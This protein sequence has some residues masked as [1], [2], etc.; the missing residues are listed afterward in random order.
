LT[1]SRDLSPAAVREQLSKLEA[2]SQFSG[3]GRLIELLRFIVEETLNDGGVALKEST[4]GNAVYGR[5]PPYDPRI[6]STV[7]VEARRLRD[8][9]RDYYAAE[10]KGDP[11]VISL[12]TG[13]Y[14]PTFSKA[15]PD[16]LDGNHSSS[17]EAEKDGL[18][19]AG[20]GAALAIMPFR[21]LSG[22]PQDDSFADGLTDELIF[23]LE[24]I[25][26]LWVASRSVV[27]QYKDRAY[28][29]PILAA[30][31]GVNA[32]L[33][34]TVRRE[35]DTIRATVELADPKGFV[36]WTDRFDVR[37][38][39]RLVL[40]E[41]IARTLFSRFRL[42]NSMMRGM[43]IS[44][45]PAALHALAKI[46]R[47]RQ[48]LDRQT[49]PDLQAALELFSDVAKEAPT[50]ARGYTGIADTYCDL[51]RLG[52]VDHSTASAS[53]NFAVGRALQLD[54]QSAEAHTASATI[55]AWLDRNP[56]AAIK[57]FEVALSLGEGAR[58]SRIYGVMLAFTG[59]HDEAA[60]LFRNARAMEPFS[61]Q[62]D[63][64]ETVCHYQAR[65]Y[66]DV[67]EVPH[68]ERSQSNSAELLV[69]KALASVFSGNTD[70][71]TAM[72]P[73]IDHIS[74]KYPDLVFSGAEIEAW[75]GL[76]ARGLKLME[77]RDTSGSAFARATLASSL[78]NDESALDALEQA[79][80]SHELSTAWRFRGLSRPA[81][82]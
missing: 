68:D 69:F 55:V 79:F 22:F 8:K 6:H 17:N 72:V 48:L 41:K 9:L 71:A 23:A 65:R 82:R 44:P 12:P 39:D 34:G 77:T 28:S 29:V 16:A 38:D 7:R 18:F 21:A 33:L 58:A 36:M 63:I 20:K 27:F 32:V 56:A 4:V 53:A 43:K 14:V 47:A 10:G 24:R 78:G 50:Y 13:G 80:E 26:G 40:Q 76:P 2:S 3:S 57:A 11:I 75:T 19:T 51:F 5:D 15:S 45:S 74:A 59:R 60:R 54:P 73:R 64:A 61:T 66:W 46:Y 70:L 62:Q 35:G 30:E 1:V 49:P 31:L 67:L 37:D 42:D 25:Q 52:L 81:R